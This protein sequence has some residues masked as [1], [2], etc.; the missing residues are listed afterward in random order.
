MQLL[1]DA[2]SAWMATT[3]LPLSDKTSFLVMRHGGSHK[4][5]IPAFFTINGR[6][7]PCG[8]HPHK[9]LGVTV[10]PPLN[11]E[12]DARCREAKVRQLLPR[13][14]PLC[15]RQHPTRVRPYAWAIGQV[16]LYGCEARTLS[17]AASV[18]LQLSSSWTSVV[19]AVMGLPSNAGNADAHLDN[20]FLSLEACARRRIMKA[21]AVRASLPRSAEDPV[22]RAPLPPAP[23]AE[24][25]PAAVSTRSSAGA[26]RPGGVLSPACSHAS[27]GCDGTV[28]THCGATSPLP[29][30]PVPVRHSH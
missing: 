7:Y 10:D 29:C 16:L 18:M 27:V 5:A 12:E 4:T 14:K 19:K 6:Q 11:F 8:N 20:A 3:G 23:R 15:G 30:A 9:I 25:S 21:A 24:P 26:D 1:C 13:L 17:C 22:L 28:A 2:V